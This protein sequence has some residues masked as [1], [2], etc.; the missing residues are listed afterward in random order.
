MRSNLPA[1][2]ELKGLL[3]EVMLELAASHPRLTPSQETAMKGILLEIAQDARN[4]ILSPA[5]LECRF[6]RAKDMAA[7]A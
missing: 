1:G 6:R 3:D 7:Q 2:I 5:E 4:G